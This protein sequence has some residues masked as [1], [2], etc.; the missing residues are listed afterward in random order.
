MDG[1][2]FLNFAKT[3]SMGVVAVA[4]V[5]VAVVA[6]A[7]AVAVVAVAVV[8]VVFRMSMYSRLQPFTTT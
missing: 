8:A 6:V 3:D 7:V 2:Y 4:V 1:P 5:A